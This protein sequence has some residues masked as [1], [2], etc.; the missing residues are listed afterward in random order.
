MLREYMKVAVVVALV[1][2]S[3]WFYSFKRIYSTSTSETTVS[4]YCRLTGAYVMQNIR[5]EFMGYGGHDCI[6]HSPAITNW[7]VNLNKD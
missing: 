6:M 4:Y 3:M 1:L 7:W 2:S 5:G